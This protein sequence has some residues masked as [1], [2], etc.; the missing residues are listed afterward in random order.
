MPDKWA[1]KQRYNISGCLKR[2][3]P[4]GVF[5]PWVYHEKVKSI[6]ICHHNLLLVQTLHQKPQWL[7]DQLFQ[8][9]RYT[10][11][12]PHRVR[13]STRRV[14]LRASAM[15]SRRR[16]TCAATVIM[17]WIKRVK[18]C[19]V[20][21]TASRA[22]TGWSGKRMRSVQAE[23]PQFHDNTQDM[24]GKTLFSVLIVVLIVA[25]NHS[26]SYLNIETPHEILKRCI[27]ADVCRLYIGY[28]CVCVYMYIYIYI[29]IYI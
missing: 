29:Y 14:S 17:S 20:T 5:L 1:E 2:G 16:S 11:F 24:V 23:Q 10:G 8:T 28:V 21:A 18:R 15:K 4:R 25:Y 6:S 22:S 27:D 7:L 12:R 3:N 13:T 9:R 19:A 26:A